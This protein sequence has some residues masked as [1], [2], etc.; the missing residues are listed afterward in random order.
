[1][2]DADYIYAF[3]QIVMPI[4][5][6]FAPDIVLGESARESLIE[7]ELTIPPDSQ[8]SAGYDAAVGD[9]LGK[10]KVS[11]AG[12]AHMTHLLS[13]LCGGKLVLALE[14]RLVSRVSARHSLT[15][16]CF[17]QGGYNVDSV[18]KSSH[19]CVEI[20][21]GDEPP[22]LPSLGPA[23][24]SATNTVYNVMRTQAPYWKSMGAAV[25]A[26]EGEQFDSL[27]QESPTQSLA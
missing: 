1:M 24:A 23:S 22:Y 13:A 16:I 10:M 3:Q 15:L 17:L 4:A 11:P 26:T 27:F 6:E 20:L 19:A 7:P 8:V 5:Y 9:D 14:V 18:V 21:V 25:E 2:G 12:Y